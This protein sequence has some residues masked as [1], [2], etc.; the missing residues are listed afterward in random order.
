MVV[1]FGIKS[2]SGQTGTVSP[3]SFAGLGEQNFR[4]TQ[5]TRFMGGLDVFSDSIHVNLNNPAAYGKLKYTTY[6]LGVNYN[7]NT[8]SSDNDDT[9]IGGAGIDY[10]SV[11]IPTKRFGFGFGMIPLTSVGYKIESL[12]ESDDGTLNN[13]F[14]GSGGV[15]QVF[16][17]VGIPILKQL[18]IGVSALY[19]FGSIDYSRSQF[20]EG[21]DIATFSEDRSTIN[22]WSYQFGSEFDL[23][24]TRNIDL[25]ALVS[26]QPE[27]KLNSEN[28]RIYYTRSLQEGTV[29]DFNEF[30]LGNQNL[31]KTEK[32]LPQT[33]KIGIGLGQKQKW[34]VGTQINLLN[35][36]NFSSKFPMRDNVTYE[37][38]RQWIIGGF[39]IPDYA[40]LTSYFNRV[41]YR[42][43]FRTENLSV[44]I[45]DRPL[46]SN[47]YSIGFGLPIQGLSNANI[48][49]EI[50][51]I[52]KNSGGL[53]AHSSVAF[54]VG[55]SLNDLW[56]IKRK[57][58]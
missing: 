4:G 55:L 43:G 16:F 17:S 27:S 33:F 52:G 48:G 23:S 22:G 25:S 51:S 5:I 21:V 29:E 1:L 37:D 11:A 46:R 20:L 54:R 2:L 19:N 41:V 15:N 10:L 24:L 42:L 3:Y 56:F 13:R 57:Y 36:D 40:S 38:S 12:K 39:Y 34:F 49:I 44:L 50:G 28:Q 7:T 31:D 58:N 30:D 45:D 14:E 6:S 26:F 47:T 32:I 35:F 8:I 9:T 18:R 53:V